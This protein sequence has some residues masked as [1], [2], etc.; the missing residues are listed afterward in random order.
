[1]YVTPIGMEAGA[2]RCVC[3]PNIASMQT[4]PAHG[5]IIANVG[6]ALQLQQCDGH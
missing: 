5:L 2:A 4:K 1:V 6:G 3:V